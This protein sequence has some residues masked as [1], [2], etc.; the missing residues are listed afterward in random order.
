MR[1]FQRTWGHAQ[2]PSPLENGM[3]RYLSWRTHYGPCSM[4]TWNITLI[5]NSDGAWRGFGLA[6][7]W[8]GWVAV[9]GGGEGWVGLFFFLLYFKM[10]LSPGQ[11]KNALLRCNPSWFFWGS[12]LL[13]REVRQWNKAGWLA[14]PRIHLP[15]PPTPGI[16]SSCYYTDFLCGSGNPTQVL[17]FKQEAPYQLNWFPGHHLWTNKTKTQKGKQKVS[18][19]FWDHIHNLR[20]EAILLT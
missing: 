17:M 6:G 4:V 9:S 8:L 16:T 11:L 19:K 18:K 15:L 7:V 20:I 13:R 10:K 3:E 5:S 14:S 12:L 2:I 1:T